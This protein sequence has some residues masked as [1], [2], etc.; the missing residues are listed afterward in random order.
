MKNDRNPGIWV[1]IWEYSVRAFLMSTNMTVFGWFSKIF[2]SASV[3]IGRVSLKRT[4][5]DNMYRCLSEKYATAVEITFFAHIYD[6]KQDVI[7]YT[8]IT[9][10]AVILDADWSKVVR[11][12]TVR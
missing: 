4:L 7:V 3:S 1:L 5:E 6:L 2:A 8:F 12:R 9:G 11:T 10:T